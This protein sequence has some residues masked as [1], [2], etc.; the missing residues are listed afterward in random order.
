MYPILFLTAYY[1]TNYILITIVKLILESQEYIIL[2]I[3]SSLKYNTL[4][5]WSKLLLFSAVLKC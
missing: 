2:E 5:L 1:C 4:K 3:G